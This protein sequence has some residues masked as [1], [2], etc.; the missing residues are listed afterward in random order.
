M[1]FPRFIPLLVLSS[2]LSLW[3]A[4]A[5]ACGWF[6]LGIHPS[7]W[8]SEAGSEG[9]ERISEAIEGGIELEVSAND[10]DIETIYRNTRE[11]LAV[12]N[13]QAMSLSSHV[14]DDLRKT[15]E[16]GL[17][18]LNQNIELI[19]ALGTQRIDQLDRIYQ[20]NLK[21]T[22]I[23]IQAQTLLLSNELSQFIDQVEKSVDASIW[24]AHDASISLANAV[25]SGELD[26]LVRLTSDEIQE[27]LDQGTSRVGEESRLTLQEAGD[28]TQ[29]VLRTASGQ[30]I[31]ITD[32]FFEEARIFSSYVFA[33]TKAVNYEVRNTRLQVIEGGLYFIDRTADAI[34][35]VS[36]TILGVVFLF[37]ACLLWGRPILQKGIPEKKLDRIIV[38]TLLGFTFIFA[39]VPLF[40]AFR[41]SIRA[42]ILLPM[43]YTKSYRDVVGAI[44]NRLPIDSRFSASSPTKDSLLDSIHTSTHHKTVQSSTAK[45]LESI[46]EN[47]KDQISS[48]PSE[49]ISHPSQTKNKSSIDPGE[50]IRQFE[51]EDFPMTSCGDERN[52]ISEHKLWHRVFVREYDNEKQLINIKSQFCTDAY[53]TTRKHLVLQG[54]PLM[55]IQVASFTSKQSAE[56]F[57]EV[58]REFGIEGLE[59]GEPHSI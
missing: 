29:L 28:Q 41:P 17:D 3:P 55:S 42:S 53:I 8:L 22:F 38:I 37:T 48:V 27:I 2:T 13:I 32:N 40:I 19:N 24:T 7:C 47:H 36:L 54:K 56:N 57:L 1:K 50:A 44:G 12:A 5:Q 30:A 11:I 14:N 33:E 18:N 25:V 16:Q 4:P 15:V 51:P 49:N 31:E 9:A 10:D 45:E 59:V 35:G 46:G 58:L 6:G 43:S 26:P 21:R 52:E 23:E 34:L 20:E 39:C